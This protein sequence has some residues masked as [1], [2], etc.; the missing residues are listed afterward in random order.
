MSRFGNAHWW[1]LQAPL[2]LAIVLLLGTAVHLAWRGSAW[3]NLLR[4]EPVV[5]L[6]RPQAPIT[7][8]A[9]RHWPTCSA[10][11]R[12]PHR[13]RLLRTSRPGQPLAYADLLV[14]RSASSKGSCI[15]ACRPSM[16][17]RTRSIALSTSAST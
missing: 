3:L 11:R 12:A 9:P 16:A 8:V 14:L 17:A 5:A 1:S 13:W 7:S 2:L 4:S 10:Y 6:P 15:M